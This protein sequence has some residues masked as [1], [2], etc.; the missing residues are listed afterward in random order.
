LIFSTNSF[1]SSDKNFSNDKYL[2][3]TPPGFNSIHTS[4]ISVFSAFKVFRLLLNSSAIGK[5]VTDSSRS[6]IAS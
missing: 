3:D 6:S 2:L 4:T 1:L 5:I